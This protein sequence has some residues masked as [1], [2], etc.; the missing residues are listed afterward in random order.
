MDYF[1]RIPSFYPNRKIKGSTLQQKMFFRA[2]KKGVG[3]N[4]IQKLN[5]KPLPFVTS[6]FVAAYA[7]EHYDYQGPIYC[8]ICDADISRAWA[9][10]NPEKSKIIYLATNERTRKRLVMYGVPKKNI[11]VTGF[12][13]PLENKG[14]D[15]LILKNDLGIRLKNLDKNN[16]FQN[17]FKALLE[18]NNILIPDICSRPLTITFAVGGA[19]AQR[20]IAFLLLKKLNKYIENDKLKINLVAGSREDVNVYFKEKIKNLNLNTNKNVK[21]IY[22]SQKVEYF[23]LFNKCLRETDVLWTKPSELSFYSALGIPIIMSEPVG[24]QEIFNREWLIEIGAGIDS[25]NLNYVDE[26]LFDWQKDGRLARA[27]FNAYLNAPRLGTEN[28]VKEVL[29]D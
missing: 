28:I 8:I 29:K 25:L 4:L 14:D 24:S 22:H 12:P 15:D 7:A 10:I 9:P 23:K 27:S 3:K 11:K 18:E 6:F 26:W 5:E 17:K 19:G 13:L 16:N 1:Q 21:I 20:E 2:V